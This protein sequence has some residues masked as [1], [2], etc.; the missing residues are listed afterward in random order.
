MKKSKTNWYALASRWTDRCS[1]CGQSDYT[2][3]GSVCGAC[4]YIAQEEDKKRRL[5]D[6][7]KKINKGGE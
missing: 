4:F 6:A 5:K 1:Y 2:V 3:V 7:E